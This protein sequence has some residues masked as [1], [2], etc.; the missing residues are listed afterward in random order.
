M[1]KESKNNDSKIFFIT[2]VQMV[3]PCKNLNM[4]FLLAKCAFKYYIN[5]EI[6]IY[7]LFFI[8]IIFMVIM[9]Y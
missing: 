5:K 8:K 4:N 6:I 1:V 3:V 7:F 9:G 2:N